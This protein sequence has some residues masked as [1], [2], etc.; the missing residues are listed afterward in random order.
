MLKDNKHI[1]SL[2]ADGLKNLSVPPNPK[3][4]E[5]V[6]TQM[7]AAKKKRLFAIYMWT[8]VA[9]SIIL[10]LAIGNRYLLNQT[11]H[12]LQL[13]TLT[14]NS[15][16]GT[17]PTK[18]NEKFIITK[19]NSQ[20]NIIESN[21][22]DF[23]DIKQEFKNEQIANSSS[24]SGNGVLDKPKIGNNTKSTNNNSSLG[25][26]KEMNGNT[27]AFL[28]NDFI[29]IIKSNQKIG[30]LSNLDY[31][32]PS[33]I[34]RVAFNLPK[35]LPLSLML[36]EMQIRNNLLAMEEA[37]VEEM[38]G[39][40]WSVIGQVS[41]SYSSYNGDSKGGNVGVGIWSL[42]GG[43]KVNYAM[44]DKLAVQTGIVY[45]KFGQDFGNRGGGDYSPMF[46][47]ENLVSGGIE[48]TATSYPSQTSAGPIRLTGSS[49]PQADGSGINENAYF[50]SSSDLLQTFEAIEIPLLLRYNLMQKRLGVFVSGGVSAN[51]IV[52]NGVYDQSNGNKR[53][54]EIDGIRTTNFSSLFSLGFEYRL[55]SK[56]LIGVEPS[57]KYYLNSIN[58]SS[59]Y[60]YKPYSIGVF[61]GI[62]YDF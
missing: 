58:T 46:A 23:D 62:R 57:L 27:H 42:G 45:N 40:R 50:A 25:F 43:A 51:M 3:V 12:E 19:D 49:L 55:S 24:L 56:I 16:T 26:V 15:N 41:S 32:L 11:E 33:N 28:D 60:Q 37:K 10:L 53:I 44:N 31:Q 29:D 59:Q 21:G 4:W 17:E 13:N 35:E 52:G 20:G 34:D 1:D 7:L 2:F 48:K 8:G 54:G 9:A 6:S 30:L 36:E 38:K 14:E 18:P 5:E 61:T 22:V 47:D 39:K